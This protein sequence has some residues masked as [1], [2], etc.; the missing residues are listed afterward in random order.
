[1]KRMEWED[2]L[3]RPSP[4]VMAK[5]SREGLK[6]VRMS[7]MCAEAIVKKLEVK[8]QCDEVIVRDKEVAAHAN[9]AETEKNKNEGTREG[10]R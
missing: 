7:L 1:M 8:P 3:I 6:A 9:G 2:T 4:E 5:K 10:G